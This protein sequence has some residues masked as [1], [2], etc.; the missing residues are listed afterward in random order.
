LMIPFS[1]RRVTTRSALWLVMITCSG[2]CHLSQVDLKLGEGWQ[3]GLWKEAGR[4]LEDQRDSVREAFSRCPSR[5]S[6]TRPKPPLIPRLSAPMPGPMACCRR[7][8]FPAFVIG[9]VLT[10]THTK[11]ISSSSPDGVARLLEW[12]MSRHQN[13]HAIEHTSFS[14]HSI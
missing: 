10:P 6:G 2:N 3:W 4:L 1:T 12:I 7:R 5:V 9:A 14:R 11:T 8:F 13:E